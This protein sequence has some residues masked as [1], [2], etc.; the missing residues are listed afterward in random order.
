MVS[1][2]TMNGA[3]VEY[4]GLVRE[5]DQ[6]FAHSLPGLM[7][8]AVVIGADELKANYGGWPFTPDTTWLNLQLIAAH[9]F[10]TLAAKQ[11]SVAK[12]CESSKPSRLAQFFVPTLTRTRR[13]ATT[14]TGST[15]R[16]FG[17]AATITTAA[18]P[19]AGVTRSSWWLWWRSWTCDRCN[20]AVVGCFFARGSIERSLHNATRMCRVTRH[21]MARW[22]GFVIGL[23]A[24]SLAHAIEVAKWAPWFGGAHAPWFLNSGRAIAFTL[25][26]C[27]RPVSSRESCGCPGQHD[28][29]RSGKRRWPSF[30]CSGAAAPS[31]RSSSRPVD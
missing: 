4:G 26:V 1:E 15:D 23:L 24:F 31:C 12:G 16:S 13:D 20:M 29:G 21:A 17:R 8:G 10:K 25:G 14:F 19:R 5:A 22:L 28:R 30:S 18:T 7:A 2:L 9:H 6:V 11:G 3:A 27:L